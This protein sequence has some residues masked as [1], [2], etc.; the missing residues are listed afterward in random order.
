[1]RIIIGKYARYDSNGRVHMQLVESHLYTIFYYR[2][3]R[4]AQEAIQFASL[5]K[6]ADYYE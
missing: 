3:L 1:M 2:G 6:E 4:H 5:N